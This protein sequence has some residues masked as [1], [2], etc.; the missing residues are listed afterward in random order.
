MRRVS[1]EEQVA[2]PN[3][4]SLYSERIRDSLRNFDSRNTNALSSS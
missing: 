1:A 4:A 3:P 2:F